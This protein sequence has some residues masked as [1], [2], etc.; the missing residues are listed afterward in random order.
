MVK[1]ANSRLN[2]MKLSEMVILALSNLW[3]AKLRTILTT[4]GVIIGI[5]ALVSMVSFGTGMQKNITD[6]IEAN[7]LFTSLTVTPVNIEL[8][9]IS[10]GSVSDMVNAQVEGHVPL[11]DSTLEV[12]RATEGVILAFPEIVF[13]SKITLSGKTISTNVRGIPIE[14]GVYA[15][16]NDLL[17]GVFFS[18]DS[19]GSVI[20][21]WETLRQMGYIVK[22]P[23]FE[24]AFTDKMKEEGKILVHSDSVTGEPVELVSAVLK[25]KKMPSNPLTALSLLNKS[26]FSEH[27]TILTVNG[28][29]RRGSP[30]AENHFNAG[31]YI[32][33]KTTEKIPR[34]GISSIWEFFNQ[35]KRE[36]EFSSIHVRVKGFKELRPVRHKLEQTGF[37]VFSVVDEIEEIRQAFLI[38]DS[39]LGAVGT[40]AL[41]VAALGIINTMVMSILERTRE[42]GIMKSVGAS[43]NEIKMIYMVEASVIGFIGAVFGL[44]LGWVV[45]L[46]ANQVFN[47]YITELGDIA[48]DLFYFP[49]WLITGAFIFSVLVSLLAGL[50]PAFR[51]ARIDPV[52]AL[53]H[54]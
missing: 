52:K 47:S 25:L 29:T 49:W 32:P 2:A 1:L 39:L 8:G 51:A 13:P 53:R 54:D 6:S 22:G 15:P 18:S 50:Y 16:F 9:N 41:I 34:V 19:A 30:F 23:D 17:D 46:I 7:E 20:I 5:G 28:I 3:Q 12:I 42:I 10:E 37:N 26:P 27:S 11:N 44:I 43:E 33:I 31:V 24:P 35:E 45:T 21:T 40:I 14:M 4:L 38:F 48:V 36:D